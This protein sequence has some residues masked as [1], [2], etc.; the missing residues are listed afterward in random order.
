MGLS[1]VDY[2]HM[3]YASSHK[4]RGSCFF[5]TST[6][7][8]HV[9]THNEITF[10]DY[11]WGAS[12]AQVTAV[13][14]LPF[15]TVALTLLLQHVFIVS[16]PKT[17][18]HLSLS[19]QH[20][21]LLGCICVTYCP[22]AWW[23]VWLDQVRYPPSPRRTSPLFDPPLPYLKQLIYVWS[24]TLVHCDWNAENVKDPSSACPLNMQTNGAGAGWRPTGAPTA[25]QEGRM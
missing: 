10:E 17:R 2:L 3:T 16:G 18:M 5:Y 12:L 8:A 1:C 21:L 14:A 4:Q 11:C 20:R 9:Q 19:I 25:G 6:A 15:L 22:F 23:I 24:R 13:P 7:V